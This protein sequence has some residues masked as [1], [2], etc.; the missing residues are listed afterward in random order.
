MPQVLTI[1]SVYTACFVFSYLL[2]LFAVPKSLEEV[3][4]GS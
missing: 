2:Q 1:S 4:E 3:S